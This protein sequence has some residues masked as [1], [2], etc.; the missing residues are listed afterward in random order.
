[1]QEMI[2][3]GRTIPITIYPSFWLL[4]LGLGWSSMSGIYGIFLFGVVV[5]ISLIAHE[6]GH[7]LTAYYFGQRVSIELT[8]L[9]GATLRLG[10]SGGLLREFLI[11]CMGP[12]ASISIVILSRLLIQINLGGAALT[13][14][15]SLM[16]IANLFWTVINLLPVQPL[17]GGKIMEIVL[18]VLFPRKGR[19][20]SFL[21]SAGFGL[22]ASLFFFS[23][24]AIFAGA[25]FM[26]CFWESVQSYRLMR[27]QGEGDGYYKELNEIESQVSSG[28]YTEVFAKLHALL[29]KTNLPK[30]ILAR[31]YKQLIELYLAQEKAREAYEAVKAA[32][33]GL[34]NNLPYQ[35]LVLKQLAAYRTSHFDESVQAGS[36]AYR[37]RPELSTAILLALASGQR[38]NTIETV[39]WLQSAKSLGFDDFKKLL[40]CSDFDSVR[41]DPTI[42]SF[43][44]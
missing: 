5:F 8:L 2:S 30:A 29:E 38:H 16:F 39:R 4:V 20:L 37:M 6:F 15:L 10:K 3:F 17:D 22:A 24:G 11:I 44:Y 33:V 21:V 7:A 18:L 19:R 41:V 23:A 27:D 14:F 26:L 12:L 43:T 40:A 9:G 42:A 36:Q 35:L 32:E 34:Q 13:P 25:I 31:A 28:Q 1:M